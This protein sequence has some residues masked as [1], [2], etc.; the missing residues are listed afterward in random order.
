MEVF[1]I[2]MHQELLKNDYEDFGSLK[3]IEKLSHMLDSELW[4]SKFDELLSFIK[5]YI[6]DV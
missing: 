1:S 4:E 5:E 6:V 2:K 3:H